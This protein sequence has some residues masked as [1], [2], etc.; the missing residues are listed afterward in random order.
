MNRLIRLVLT[1]PVS[2][3]TTERAFSAMKLVKTRL[4]NKMEDGFL[5]DC[6][7]TYIEKE[8]A[9]EISTDTIIDIFDEAPRRVDF[10]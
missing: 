7:V 9:V 1:L 5:R 2:T 3:A 4:R 8:I 10:N 6:L